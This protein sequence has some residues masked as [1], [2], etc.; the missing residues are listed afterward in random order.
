E[1]LI[2][3]YGVDKKGDMDFLLSIV[4][5]DIAVLT[6][7]FPV[8]MNDDQFKTLDDIYNEK[9]KLVDGLK[10]H[11]VAILNIDNEYCAELAKKRGKKSTITYGKAE[12]ADFRATSVQ[13]GRDGL[14]F[15]L[16]YDDKK[17]SVSTGTLGEYHVY[18]FL[19]AI[20]CGVLLGMPIENVVFSLTKYAS[21]PG[22]LNL[23]QGVNDSVILDSSY[24]SSPAPLKEALKVLKEIGG[25]DRKIAVLGS[26]NELGEYSHA[27]HR[28]I[29]KLIPKYADLLITVGE[30]AKVFGTEALAHGF[31]VTQVLSFDSPNDAAEAFKE[32]IKPGDIFLVKGSQNKV[33]LEKFIKIIMANPQDAQKLLV[34]Q[35][36]V[37]EDIF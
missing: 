9:R 33:R 13:I 19:P 29:G 7:V 25:N 17:Q 14:N 35:E 37:W 12:N 22:R 26:M 21:P 15:I 31:E 24:N 28:E 11:G 8:H 23:I 16:H 4:R 20:I 18:V 27:L 32:K 10:D 5:P 36:N 1:V 3:E 34:R 6:N 30:D 2:L